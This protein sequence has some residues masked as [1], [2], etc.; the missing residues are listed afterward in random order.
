M[1]VLRRNLL[2]VVFQIRKNSNQIDVETSKLLERM[3]DY[4]RTQLISYPK[5]RV[6]LTNFYQK[7]GID[8]EDSKLYDCKE[9]F[10]M[11]IARIIEKKQATLDESD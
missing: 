2:P 9:K 10:Y 8:L 4:E 1:H 6:E 3:V 7:S 11:E 5:R